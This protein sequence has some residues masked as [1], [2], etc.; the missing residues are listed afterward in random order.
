MRT[1]LVAL[2]LLSTSAALADHPTTYSPSWDRRPPP[3]WDHR[4]LAGPARQLDQAATQLYYAVR[5]RSGQ[6]EL[7]ERARELAEST[8]DFR[9]LAERGAHPAQLH[10]A[11]QRVGYRYSLVERRLDHRGREY[12]HRYATAQL[13]EVRRA[14]DQTG[15]ALQRFA[16]NWRDRRDD[17]RYAHNP[18]EPWRDWRHDHDD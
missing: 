14:F 5:S 8:R 7:T 15:L 1:L 12:R 11:W 9:R 13:E 10:D 17:D 3:A 18:R 2:L 4:G 6:G 16:R